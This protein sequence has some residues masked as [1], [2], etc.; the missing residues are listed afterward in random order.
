MSQ[1]NTSHHSFHHFLRQGA[2]VTAVSA[3][4]SEKQGAEGL[5]LVLPVLPEASAGGGGGSTS[6]EVEGTDAASD[7]KL[8]LLSPGFEI[9]SAAVVEPMGAQDETMWVWNSYIC[10]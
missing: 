10:S 2:G 4:S 5:P 7:G 8:R 9:S 1:A 6:D 3:T